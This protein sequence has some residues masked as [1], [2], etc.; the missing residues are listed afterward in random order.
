M[1]LRVAGVLSVLSVAFVSTA[2][3]Q[4]VDVRSVRV[5]T[6]EAHIMSR[7]TI[8]SEVLAS[9]A[10][11]AMLE[12]LDKLDDWYWVLI[13]RDVHGTQR[14][15]WIR[16]SDLEGYVKPVEQEER[17]DENREKGQEEKRA[18]KQEEQEPQQETAWTAPATD[19]VT[20]PEV[21]LQEALARSEEPKKID[22]RRLRKME[23]EIEKAR[24]R[25][26]RLHQSGS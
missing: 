21:P 23:Q 4:G 17:N 11:G 22:V 15:G 3:A 12:A 16:E 9:P 7:P 20:L 25:L 8:K 1:V 10:P 2:S 19:P 14:A 13:D 26:E 24:Q 18:E 6:D 5:G